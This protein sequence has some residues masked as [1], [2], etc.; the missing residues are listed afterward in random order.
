MKRGRVLIA[1]ADPMIGRVL[2]LI[3][4]KLDLE[5]HRSGS[6][7]QAR[8]LIDQEHF[9]IML[10]EIRSPAAGGAELLKEARRKAP[11]SSIIALTS[12]GAEDAALQA[13]KLG[14]DDFLQKPFDTEQLRTLVRRGLERNNALKFP[15]VEQEAEQLMHELVGSSRSIL[16]LKHLIERVARVKSPVLI[17]GEPGAGKELVGRLIHQFS[18]RSQ[19]PFVVVDCPAIPLNMQDARLFGRVRAEG[20]DQLEGEPGFFELAN[21]GTVYLSEIAGL[22]LTVQ[23]KILAALEDNA[24][25]RSGSDKPVQTDVRV[26]ASTSRNLKQMFASRL[27]NQNLFRRLSL[28]PIIVP[29]LREYKED[30]PLLINHQLGRLRSTIKH[31]VVGVSPE[32]LEILKN[33]DFPG[34]VRELEN[35]IEHSVLLST[36]MILTPETL[37]SQIVEAA[38]IAELSDKSAEEGLTLKQVK[39]LATEKTESR[40]IKRVLDET[41][42][43]FSLAARRLGI[44]R[45]ALYY[46]IKKYRIPHSD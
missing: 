38:E 37:P 18:D 41:R 20:S 16:E 46:K 45:S 33:Y 22:E 3:L 36:G 15:G 44:S 12:Y 29:A 40:L 32:Y 43:N 39:A 25:L 1:D 2:S 14:A 8:A 9:D 24:I 17:S 26:I 28:V 21:K 42:G 11:A 13:M 5:V 31:Q 7:E 27:F 35:I 10:I 4:E 34:N 19:G 6:D 23:S 30:L